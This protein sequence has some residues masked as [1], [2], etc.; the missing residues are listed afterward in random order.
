M[1]QL[2]YYI[3]FA[4]AEVSRRQ[5]EILLMLSLLTTERATD[6]DKLIDNVYICPLNGLLFARVCI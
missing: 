4:P 3:L 1:F 6:I 2:V 5:N